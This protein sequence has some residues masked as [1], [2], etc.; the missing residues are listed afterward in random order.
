[1]VKSTHYI[2]E[3]LWI[4]AKIAINTGQNKKLSSL[5]M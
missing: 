2:G 3:N 1:M 4:A 5:G